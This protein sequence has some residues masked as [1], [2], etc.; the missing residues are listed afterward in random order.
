V[1]WWYFYEEAGLDPAPYIVPD[2]KLYDKNHPITNIL[3]YAKNAGLHVIFVSTC[4][5]SILLGG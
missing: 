1:G 4:P 3:R 2:E 5:Q